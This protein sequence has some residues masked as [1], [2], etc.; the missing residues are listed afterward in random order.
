MFVCFCLCRALWPALLSAWG[1]C[2]QPPPSEAQLA[3]RRAAGSAGN[4]ASALHA[5][6]LASRGLLHDT[7]AA[8]AQV[9]RP[10][11]LA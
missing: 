11:L 5:L 7:L 4:A 8:C 3:A 2:L 10:Q 9:G 1:P 6:D